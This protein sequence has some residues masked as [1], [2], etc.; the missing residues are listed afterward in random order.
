MKKMSHIRIVIVSMLIFSSLSYAAEVTLQWSPNVETDLVGYFCY[1]K[2]ENCCDPYG[3]SG[4]GQGVSPIEIPLDTPGFNPN[5]PEF[6][7]TGLDDNRPYYFVISAYGDEEESGYSNEVKVKA[8]QLVSQPV[9]I[10]ASN[11][12]ATIEWTTDEFSDSEV[13]YGQNNVGWSGYPQTKLTDASGV[14]THRVTLTGLLPETTYNFR[15]GSTNDFGFGPDFES[16]DTN[17]SRNYDFKTDPELEPDTIPP[18]FTMQPYAL[19]IT[20][21]SAT[22]EWETDEAATSTVEYG[23]TSSYGATIS[24]NDIYTTNHRIEVGGLDAETLYHARVRS[25]DQAGN[26]TVSSD[27]TFETTTG[28]DT[29][30]P[31]FTSPPTVVDTTDTSVVVE[32]TTNEPGNSRMRWGTLSATWDTYPSSYNDWYRTTQ[33]R[34]VLTGLTPDTLYYTRVVSGDVYNNRRISPEFTF[35]TDKT[36]DFDAPIITTAPTVVAKTDTTAIIVWNTDEPANS[37]V[38]YWDDSWV[39][40]R[41]WGNYQSTKNIAE[42]STQ[43]S[44]TLTNLTELTR[45][46]FMVGSTDAGGNGPTTS[47]ESNFITEETPDLKAPQIISPPTVTAKTNQTITIEW[48]TDEPS[49]SLVRYGEASALWDM[50]PR[51]FFDPEG[52]T[53]HRVVIAGLDAEVLYY[54][55]V[56][57]TDAYNNGPD[58]SLDDSNPSAEFS[59]TTDPDPDISAPQLTAPPT[60]TAKTDTVAVI[61]WSTDEPSTSIVRYDLASASWEQYALIENDS[62]MV[63]EHSVVLVN[64]TPNQ[65]YYFRTGSVDEHGNGPE[66]RSGDNNPSAEVFFTTASSAD[67]TAPRIT[68]PPTVT[69]ITDTMAMVEWETDEPSNSAVKY[70]KTE[71]NGDPEDLW[72]TPL[73]VVTNNRMVTR[74]SITLTNLEND[75]R[76][77]FMAGS[78]NATG[79]GPDEW[80][81]DDIEPDMPPNNPFTQDFFRTEI[82]KDEQAPKIISGPTVTAKDNQ[83]AIIEWETDEP[84]NSIV[85][86][87]TTAHTWFVLKY[88]APDLGFEECTIDEDEEEECYPVDEFGNSLEEGPYRSESDSEMVTHHSVTITDLQPSTTYYF[89]VG[90]TDAL[91][92]GPELNQDAANPSELGQLTTEVGPDELAPF[93]F[94][95]KADDVT[96][97]TNTTALITWTTDEPSNSIV[98]YG[99]AGGAWDSYTFQESD[100]GMLQNHSLTIT[101]LQPSTVYYFRVGS[102]DAVG[103]G[104]WL[105]LR[106]GNPSNEVSFQS[107]AGPDITAPQISNLVITAIND[108]TAIVEWMTDE[109]GNSQ[110]HYD[111]DSH[112]WPDYRFG[113]NDAEMVTEHSVTLTGISPSTLYYIRVSSTD[114]SGNNYATSQNDKNPSIE[115]NLTT[116]EAD[117]PSVVEYPDPDYPTVD[118]VN[119]TIEIT[120]DEPNMQNAQLE[121]NY[122]FIPS[123]IFADPGKSILPIS[124]DNERSTYRYYFT[125]VPAYTVFTLTLGEEITDTDGYFVEPATILINDNDSDGL[126]DDWESDVGLDPES[127]DTA[128]GQGSEG[129]YDQDGFSNYEEFLNSTEPLDENS[130]PSPPGILDSVPHHRAGIDDNFRVP[131]NSSFGLF[132]SDTAGIDTTDNGS[133]VFS[134]DDQFNPIYVVDVGDSSV[135]RIIKMN[136]TEPDTRVTSFW[137]VYD[138]SLDAYGSFPFD[139]NVDIQVTVTNVN[140]YVKTGEYRFRIETETEHNN[141]STEPTLPATSP[142]DA[143][144]PDLTDATHTY[145]AGFQI[146]SGI[147]QGTKIVFHDSEPV[148][149][150]FAPTDG[151]PN[152]LDVGLVN[153]LGGPINVQPSTIFNTPVKLIIPTQGENASR[154]QIYVYNGIWS[155]ATDT[156]GSIEVPGWMVPDSRVDGSGVIQLKVRHFSGVHT[157]VVSTGSGGGG[158]GDDIVPPDDVGT[159]L[160]NSMFQYDFGRLYDVLFF[161]GLLLIGGG[162][163]ILMRRRKDGN[164]R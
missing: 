155:L 117:P 64:L 24:I 11:N 147:M 160:V 91:G 113:E 111:T 19:S 68:V 77:Y 133:V 46:Y 114:A 28:I 122:I 95:L 112:T 30:S 16:D 139:E 90:S 6:T 107:A 76:Y 144:D 108:Q 102:M 65:T 163:V 97:K 9:V 50:F 99:L 150:E 140:A 116:V 136:D 23:P 14:T 3:G 118:W 26:E 29:E 151:I 156:D 143:G 128:S 135:M 119:N 104:P 52:V 121:S 71:L 73:S 47:F 8:P 103:N 21:Q 25:A 15:V 48:V 94:D 125:A 86:F 96:F 87:D 62:D 85:R 123:L 12:A 40:L 109:P 10:Y 158:G 110:V 43:H 27:F 162:I 54:F 60:V 34:I 138:R 1:Y 36:P 134:V 57:G 18:Q 51:S 106:S 58:T 20:D 41:T 59:V 5:Q 82:A 164:T 126:P 115:R 152:F 81:P 32:F 67:T 93:I 88:G 129:D 105:N 98:Q 45:Y 161:A 38:R 4:S 78:T 31:I 42:L 142:L 49:N 153:G 127:G 79:W 157:A 92:N 33:H 17:P 61:E 22:I 130:F 75:T 44:V 145:N 37:I 148:L 80:G 74:H 70:S 124:T 131:N 66:L 154:I 13:R 63:D 100:A 146:D 149:P 137:I 84:S 53:N 55:R 101:G 159:C 72:T 141:A 132:V 39:G 120:Y 2:P 69:G 56:G 7:I 35:R 89:R 83:S